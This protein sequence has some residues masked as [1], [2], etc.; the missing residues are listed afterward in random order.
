MTKL[1]QFYDGTYGIVKGSFF[2]KKWLSISGQWLSPI[3]YPEHD[4]L[5]NCKFP[6]GDEAL[7]KFESVRLDYHIISSELDD[8]WE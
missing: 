2:W 8:S 4:I 6:T 7:E 1:V 3:S 5:K